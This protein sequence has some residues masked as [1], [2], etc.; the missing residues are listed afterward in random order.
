MKK[1]FL[2]LF[3][4]LGLT[5]CASEP[6]PAPIALDYTRYGK[7]TLNT[8][9]IHTINRAISAQPRGS[10]SNNFQ[11]RLVDALNKW[12][13]DRLD[14]RGDAGHTTVII[15]EASLTETGLPM[16]TGVDA[17][18]KRQQEKKYT[19][20]VE[21]D[22]ESQSPV[23]N[24]TGFATARAIHAVTLPED[25]T[26]TEKFEAYRAV[27]DATMADFN[28]AMEQSVRSHL[29]RFIIP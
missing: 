10:L 15:K 17:W 11:P 28:E 24:L 23:G 18:F 14:A 9:D 6:M 2:S 5:A 1:T 25:A 21:M 29:S 27:L 4:I 3:L 13:G 26:E 19:A 12:V 22:I 7:I 16:E 8:Q 20:R